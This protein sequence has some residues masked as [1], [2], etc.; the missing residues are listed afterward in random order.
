[1]GLGLVFSWPGMGDPLRGDRLRDRVGLGRLDPRELRPP[2]A[3]LP[4]P[5]RPAHLLHQAD[6]GAGRRHPRG[7]PRARVHHR[8]RVAGGVRPPAGRCASCSP[9]RSSPSARS[10]TSTGVRSHRISMQAVLHTVRAVLVHRRLRELA[11]CS[12][13]WVG[14][15]AIYGA[16][17]FAFLADGARVPRRRRR[18]GCSRPETRP[19]SGRGFSGGGSR[20]RFLNARAPARRACGGDGGGE[21]RHRLVRTRLARRSR[22]RGRG[23]LR[24]HSR[25][26]GTGCCSPRSRLSPVDRIGATTGG[27]LLFTSTGIMVFPAHLRSDPRGHRQLRPG[28]HRRRPPRSLHRPSDAP[29]AGAAPPCRAEPG[30]F[31]ATGAARGLPPRPVESGHR[32]N[33][34]DGFP[35]SGGVPPAGGSRRAVNPGPRGQDARAPR[36]RLPDDVPHVPVPGGGTRAHPEPAASLPTLGS[37]SAGVVI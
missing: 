30:P 19:P 21:H 24:R 14:L 25:S 37:A 20:G 31:H 36:G 27:V 18:G 4:A 26:V 15:Q 16:F 12:V 33:P 13:S 7:R 3:L 29:A 28:V 32:A 5:A 9:S 2:R 10:S 17:L 1:M 34:G 35:G 11:L 22:R 6:R 8:P 23:G